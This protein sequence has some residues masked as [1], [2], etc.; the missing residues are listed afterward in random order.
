M[1]LGNLE[2]ELEPP[3]QDLIKRVEDLLE[4]TEE[5]QKSKKKCIKFKDRLV[6]ETFLKRESQVLQRQRKTLYPPEISDF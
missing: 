2:K 3:Q 4:K 6:R 5:P 1:I